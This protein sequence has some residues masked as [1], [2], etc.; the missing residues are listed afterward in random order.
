MVG[1]ER[2]E[3]PTPVMVF[4]V[5]IIAASAAISKPPVAADRHGSNAQMGVPDLVPRS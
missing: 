3:F 1:E 5:S 4:M 2:F